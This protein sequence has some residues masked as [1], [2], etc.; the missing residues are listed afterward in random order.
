MLSMCRSAL[1]IGTS[2]ERR[3]LH[4]AVLVQNRKS[5]MQTALLHSK[6]LAKAGAT[7]RDAKVPVEAANVRIKSL[8]I[9]DCELTCEEIDWNHVAAKYVRTRS[10]IDCK[11]QWTNCDNPD[12]RHDPW[13]KEEDGRLLKAAEKYQMHNWIA[14][15]SELGVRASD[16]DIMRVGG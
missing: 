14:I 6:E 13:S 8:S 5:I 7:R 11:I 15:A 9:E 10:P 1:W 12:I 3:H 4:D 2:D 16:N